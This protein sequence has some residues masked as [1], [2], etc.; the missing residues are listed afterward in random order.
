M[1][2]AYTITYTGKGFSL[3]EAYSQHWTK[4]KTKKDELKNIFKG[5]IE[6]SGIPEITFFKLDVRFNARYDVDNITP[7]LKLFVDQLRYSEIITEDTKDIYTGF[8]VTADSSLGKNT[9]SFKVIPL[10]K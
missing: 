10:E 6:E 3:N 1:I 7:M 8:S 5:L 2:T 4:A 9:Y